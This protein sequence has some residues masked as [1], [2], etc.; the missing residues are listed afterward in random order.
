MR[1]KH[2]KSDLEVLREMMPEVFAEEDP[3]KRLIAFVHFIR[4]IVRRE[5]VE[6]VRRARRLQRKIHRTNL[7]SVLFF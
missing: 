2:A 6:A 5:V 7:R 4:A 3:D 1:K